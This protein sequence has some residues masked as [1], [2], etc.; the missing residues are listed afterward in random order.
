MKARA[1]VPLPV[2]GVTLVDDPVKVAETDVM[3]QLWRFLGTGVAPAVISTDG[4]RATLQD[5]GGNAI[6]QTDIPI[7]YYWRPPS[8]VGLYMEAL[9]AI[10][11]GPPPIQV[12]PVSTHDPQAGIHGTAIASCT[13]PGATGDERRSDDRA[14]RRLGRRDRRARKKLCQVTQAVRPALPAS[15]CPSAT[16]VAG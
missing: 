9:G 16:G 15:S 14:E 2:Y 11:D 13:E 5:T 10:S 4:L 6:A 12:R 3:R 8:V 7:P 1:R